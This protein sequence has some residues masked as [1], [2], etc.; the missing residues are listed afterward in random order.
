MF[1]SFQG[2]GTIASEEARWGLH[3]ELDRELDY[4]IKWR[5]GVIN[6][7]PASVA[8]RAERPDRIED[9]PFVY[10]GVYVVSERVRR[11]IEDAGPGDCQFVR[12][13]VRFGRRSLGLDYWIMHVNQ[14]LD[15]AD[16]EGSYN[17][18]TLDEQPFFMHANIIPARVPDTVSTFRVRHGTAKAIM[19]NSLKLKLVRAKVTGCMF[20]HP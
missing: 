3:I 14:V 1:S 17:V 8:G 5:E 13:D 11:M 20:Y 15:C 12:V 9:V 7:I 19:R 6:D 10:Q 2:I 4:Q 18:N 16:P